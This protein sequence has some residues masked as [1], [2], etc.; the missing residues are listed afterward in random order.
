MSDAGTA[1]PVPPRRWRRRLLVLGALLIAL[2]LVASWLLQPKQLVPLIL[3]RAGKALTLEIS[4]SPDAEAR[5]RGTP[6]LVVRDLVVREPGGE[7]VLLRAKRVLLS[8]PWSSVRSAGKD[9]VI[10]RVELDEPEL[11]LAAL[12][13]WLAKRPPSEETAIPTLTD[14]LRVSDGRVVDGTLR[15]EDLTIDLPALHPQR[16]AHAR[17]RGRLVDAPLKMPLDLVVAMSRP[18]NHAGLGIV[19]TLAFEGVDWRLPATVKLSGPL[20]IDDDG[21]A[22]TPA[23]LGATARYESGDTRLP[24]A[25]G[26]HGP[27]RIVDGTAT[28]SPAGVALRGDG[29]IPTLDAHGALSLGKHL[30]LRLDGTLPRW[31]EAW[32]ALPPPISTSTSPLPFALRYDGKSDLSDITALSL[33]RDAMVFDSRFRLYAMLDWLAQAGGSPLPPMDGTLRAPQLEIS[34][35][36]LEGVQVSLDDEGTE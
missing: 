11:D 5:L 25:L 3:D 30:V 6:Q 13:A 20:R 26:L 16:R 36:T 8:L 28:L 18:A 7:A 33:R 23:T 29:T 15:I 19:G 17:L 34:G 31:P 1:S 35:A 22:M 12:R 32:P 2:S 21:M 10:R 14:G 9:I 24:F 27:L 4:A